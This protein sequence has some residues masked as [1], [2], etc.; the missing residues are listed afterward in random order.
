MGQEP[1]STAAGAEPA[2]DAAARRALAE[3]LCRPVTGWG[4]ANLEADQNTVGAIFQRQVLQ[5][6]VEAVLAAGWRPPP[7]RLTSEDELESCHPGTVITDRDGHPWVLNGAGQWCEPLP[8]GVYPDELV[9]WV[10]L[11][12]HVVV[13]DGPATE[14]AR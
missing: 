14:V 4:L 6:T 13:A 10:P 11:T 5:E 7:L 3:V 9:E 8:T 2:V 1:T 12:V